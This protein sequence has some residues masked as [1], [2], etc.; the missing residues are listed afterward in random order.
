MSTGTPP[1]QKS[2]DE[3]QVEMKAKK[4]G[5]SESQAPAVVTTESSETH[6]VM[7]GTAGSNEM[8]A[9]TGNRETPINTDGPKPGKTE[10]HT[11]TD[12]PNTGN[13]AT[14]TVSNSAQPMDLNQT[15]GNSD[16]T[17]ETS[18]SKTGTVSNS[19]PSSNA[20]QTA[21]AAAHGSPSNPPLV[22][23]IFLVNDLQYDI[24]PVHPENGTM[25]DTDPGK[26]PFMGFHVQMVM[27]IEVRSLG[28]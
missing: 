9:E 19:T 14:E 23:S 25:C 12:G 20:D 11:E 24:F 1:V 18:G 15:T 4:T 16:T 7:N 6:T 22:L 5:Q 21:G 26:Y 10:S 27:R 13:S 3:K 8:H 28:M 17:T 2:T